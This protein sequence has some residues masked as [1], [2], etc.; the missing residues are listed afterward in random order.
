MTPTY[1]PHLLALSVGMGL[2]MAERICQEHGGA[3]ELACPAGGG[4]LVRLFLP[5]S[6]RAAEHISP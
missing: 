1:W 2:P 3:M 6:P 5:H 4:C